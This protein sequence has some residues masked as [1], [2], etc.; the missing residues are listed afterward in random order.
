MPGEHDVM[1]RE[2]KRPGRT[3]MPEATRMG[4]R[5]M[6]ETAHVGSAH[7]AASHVSGSPH[8]A[9]TAAEAEAASRHRGRTEGAT[10]RYRR[11]SGQRD[12]HCTQH[13]PSPMRYEFEAPAVARRAAAKHKRGGN[14]PFSDRVTRTN[15]NF[16]NY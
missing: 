8:M 11:S 7:V 16:S 3:E 1:A 9:A 5:G 4:K 10:Q 2:P 12:R 15:R 6:T 14:A 13:D